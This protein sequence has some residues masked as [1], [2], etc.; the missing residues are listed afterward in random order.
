MWQFANGERELKSTPILSKIPGE[1]V[2]DLALGGVSVVA[3]TGL[4]FLLLPIL[5]PSLYLVSLFTPSH[6]SS[7]SGNVYSWGVGSNG[8]LGHGDD[9]DRPWPT[10]LTAFDDFGKRVVQIAGRGGHHMALTGNSSLI[11]CPHL[12]FI[13]FTFSLPLTFLFFKFFPLSHISLFPSSPSSPFFLPP[14]PPLPA[15]FLY[16][17]PHLLLYLHSL[18]PPP[19][20][21]PLVPRC[22][23][24]LSPTSRPYTLTDDGTVYTWGL[25][26]GGRLGHGNEQDHFLPLPVETLR[27]RKAVLVAAGLDSSFVVCEQE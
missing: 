27:K 7:E 3:L 25:G 20:P 9:E 6:P 5:F 10:P 8:R 1:K 4:T 24:P 22:F 21:S 15:S 17:S 18:T 2:V 13:F 19:P 26:R 12:P 14:L 16:I 23:L 11:R